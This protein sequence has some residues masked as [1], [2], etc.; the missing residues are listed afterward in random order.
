MNPAVAMLLWFGV[1]AV[2]ALAFLGGV[3]VGMRLKAWEDGEDAANR[4]DAMKEY[5]L[6]NSGGE[7]PDDHTEGF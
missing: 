2:V 1:P 5:E 7:W 4:A 3:G 6:R